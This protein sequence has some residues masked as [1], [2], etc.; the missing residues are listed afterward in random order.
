MP[1]EDDRRRPEASAAVIAI[2]DRLDARLD[3]PSDG[4]KI[5]VPEGRQGVPTGSHPEPLR[6]STR[7]FFGLAARAIRENRTFTAVELRPI[8]EGA[9]QAAADGASLTAVLHNW[10]RFGRT[11]LDECRAAAAGER[12]AGLVEIASA[13]LRLQETITSAVV[14]SYES[15]RV[16]LD[17]DEKP[18]KELLA[19]L[20]L[21]GQDADPTARWCGIE[22]SDEYSVLALSYVDT[23]RDP[24]SQWSADARMA[25]VLERNGPPPVLGVLEQDGGILLVPHKVG[26]DID[27]YRRA[28]VLVESI[29][30]A[31]DAPV[32][33]AVTEPVTRARIADSERLAGELLVLARRLGR[34]PAVY[35]LK[36]LALPFQLSRPTEGRQY[37]ADW[38]LPLDP[39]PELVE[40]LDAYLHHDLDR[41]RTA[42]ALDVHPNTVNNRL[43][44]IRDLAGVDPSRYE[45][46]MTL[47]SALDARRARGW[48]PGGVQ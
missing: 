24:A 17:G 43:G 18:S 13:V 37:L 4:R 7:R 28:V 19:R 27:W 35:Q 47:G 2:L 14:E 15:E 3:S 16:A 1:S 12:A 42:R 34:E 6:P 30:A 23:Q 38:L 20:L 36:D 21:A 40:T 8:R 9:V 10:H 25:R 45:G 39:Y 44:R 41:G 46:I 48:E 5:R 11:L 26:G 22:L 29:S 32:T 33:G 31:V